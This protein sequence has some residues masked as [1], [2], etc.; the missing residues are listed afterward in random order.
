MS[1]EERKWVGVFGR[2]PASLEE[3]LESLRK[4]DVLRRRMGGVV[5][6]VLGVGKAGMRRVREVRKAE[7]EGARWRWEVERY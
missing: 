3:G 6:M 7:G 2:M 1:E 5:D 4:D